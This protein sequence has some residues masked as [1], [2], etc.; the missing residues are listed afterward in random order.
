MALSDFY[1]IWR[2]GGSSRSQISMIS[3][4]YFCFAVIG[5]L[6]LGPTAQRMTDTAAHNV[7]VIGLLFR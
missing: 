2:G 5:Q 7:P 6:G 3:A 1:E 4:D